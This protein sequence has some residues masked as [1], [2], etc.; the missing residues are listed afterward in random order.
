MEVVRS[1]RRLLQKLRCQMMVMDQVGGGEWQEVIRS[2]I[3]SGG[4]AHIIV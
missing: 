3:Q 2:W 1:A 4:R